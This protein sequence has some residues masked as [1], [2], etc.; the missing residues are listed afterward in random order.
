LNKDVDLFIDK[1]MFSWEFLTFNIN[2]FVRGISCD[3][4]PNTEIVMV[5]NQQILPS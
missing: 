5:F 4:C 1:G 3:F 2:R